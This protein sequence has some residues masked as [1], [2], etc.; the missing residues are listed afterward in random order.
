MTCHPVRH[1]YPS[2]GPDA[3]DQA[4]MVLA[5][6]PTALGINHFRLLFPLPAWAPAIF[7]PVELERVPS[8]KRIRSRRPSQLDTATGH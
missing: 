1:M 3:D 2:K 6:T 5:Q 4:S 8:F 7:A